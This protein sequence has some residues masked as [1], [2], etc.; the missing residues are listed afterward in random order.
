MAEYVGI[1]FMESM[2]SA[3]EPFITE[4][5]PRVV[6]NEPRYDHKTGL[7]TWVEE[8]EVT[9]AKIIVSYKDTKFGY[10]IDDENGEP[11]HEADEQEENESEEE[12]EDE[13]ND[14]DWDKLVE[15]LNAVAADNGFQV[16]VAGCDDKSEH[17]GTEARFVMF[18]PLTQPSIIDDGW[19]EHETVIDVEAVPSLL[20][21]LQALKETLTKLGYKPGKPVIVISG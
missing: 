15:L 5:I 18:T 19:S 21:G 8:I 1:G 6:R 11:L 7:Q 16:D 10:Y 20:P 14:G 9:K 12:D 2:G 17:Y 3:L 13:P 4:R